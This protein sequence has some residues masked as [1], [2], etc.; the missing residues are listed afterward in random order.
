MDYQQVTR[1]LEIF[2][3]QTSKY[4]SNR[5]NLETIGK[6]TAISVATYVVV[7]VCMQFGYICI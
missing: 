1:H 4:L 7:D 2:S 6:I 3:Q 5:S